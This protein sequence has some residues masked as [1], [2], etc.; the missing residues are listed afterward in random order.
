MS[1]G[2]L[3]PDTIPVATRCRVLLIPDSVDWIAIV[4]GA[5]STLI[6]PDAWQQ[7]GTLTPE[8]CAERML[9]M[10]DEFTFDG[11]CPP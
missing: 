9:Q 3:T 8:E 10:L 5:L 1:Y 4:T 7:Y 2:Y 6:T 11:E